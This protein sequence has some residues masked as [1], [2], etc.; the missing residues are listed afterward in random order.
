MLAAECLQ[1]FVDVLHDARM[2]NNNNSLIWHGI[3]AG[4]LLGSWRYT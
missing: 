2:V 3:P 1:A 4:C